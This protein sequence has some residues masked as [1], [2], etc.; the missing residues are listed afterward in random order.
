MPEKAVQVWN[1]SS[2]TVVQPYNQRVQGKGD[3]DEYDSEAQD[4]L[5]YT[6][7]LHIY[8]T[9]EEVKKNVA[10]H[11]RSVQS[12]VFENEEFESAKEDFP[13]IYRASSDFLLV[14][15]VQRPL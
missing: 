14:P 4:A 7:F 9:E 6:L 2:F 10:S 5:L 12:I 1:V 11:V 8:R 13:T 15:L 3:R